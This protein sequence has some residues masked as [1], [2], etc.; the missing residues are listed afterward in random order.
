[1]E[2]RLIRISETHQRIGY[3]L[4]NAGLSS[5]AARVM[6]RETDRYFAIYY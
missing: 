6:R 2:N 4:E 1:M 3:T 5:R